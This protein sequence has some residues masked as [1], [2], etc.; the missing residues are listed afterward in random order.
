MNFG[1]LGQLISSITKGVE[2]GVSPLPVIIGVVLAVA[3]LAMLLVTVFTL[4]SIKRAELKSKKIIDLPPSAIQGEKEEEVVDNP[5][6]TTPWPIGEW[7]NK[8]L[9][10]KGYI[11]VNNI[12]RSFF[13]AMDFLKESLGSGYKYKLPWYMII[14]TEE[15]GKSSLLSGFTHDEIFDDEK[16]DPTCTWWFLR[17]GVV[18]DIKGNALIPKEGYNA[19]EKSWGIILSMLSRYRSAKPLNGIILTIPA[20]ELY[21]KNRVPLDSIKKRA[22]FIAKKLSFAQNYL[23]MKLPIYLVITKTDIVPGFQSFCSE[24]PVKNRSNML[25]WSSPYSSD[26][27]YYSR[28]LE[29]GFAAFENELNEIRMEIFSESSIIATRDGVFV[30]P[31]E[32]LSIKE[33]LACYI[34]TIFKSASV[35]ERFYFRGFY[36]TGDSKMVPLL[37]FDNKSEQEEAMA[38]L[39]TPDADINEVGNLTASF[40]N[41][42]FAPKKIFFFEDLL[43]KKVF[44]EDGI[45]SPM[46]SKVYQS[47]KSIFI[48]KVSTAAFVLIGSYGL[49]STKDQFNRNKEMLCPSLFKISSIIKNANDLTLKNLEDNGNEILSECT[50]QLLSMMQQ[51]NNARFSSL[52]V[53]ASWFS[54]INKNLTETLRI[55]YQRVVIRTIYMNLILKARTLF[56]MKPVH[57]SNDIAEVLNPN[58]SKEYKQLKSYVAELIELQ[59]NI[60]KFDSLRT[61]GDPKDLSDLIDYTFQGSLP[62]EFLDNYQQFRAILMNTPF[63]PLD[64]SPYKKV[65]YDVLISLFQGYL[66]TIFTTRSKNSIMAILKGFLDSLTRQNLKET[67]N[68]AK[69]KAFSKGLTAVCKELGQEG[70]TWLDKD[71]FEPDQEYDSFLDAVEILF[72]KETAQKLLDIT[73]INFGYLKARLSEFNNILNADVRR[74]AVAKKSSKEPQFPSSGIFLME[75]CLSELYSYAFME[76]PE[77]YQLI[78]DIPFGKMIFWDDELVQ[79]AYEIGKSF[80]QFI[81][82]S[83]KD[84]PKSMQEGITLLAKSN[85]CAVISSTIAKS[86][87]LVDSPVGLT[88]ELTSEE[89]LQKQVAELKGVAPRFVSLLQTLRE[90]KFSFVFGNLRAILNKIAFSLLDYIDKLLENQR[91]YYPN[92]LKFNYWNGEA[93]AGLHAYSASDMEELILYLQLQRKLMTRLASDFAEPIVEFLNSEI[94]FDKNFGNQGQ[95]TRWTRIADN[96]KALNK[97]DPTN[98]IS[99]VEK[100]ILRTLN[101]YDLDNITTK[102]SQKDLEGESGDYFTNIIKE[103]KRG[104]MARAEI[105]IRKRNIARYNALKDYYTKHLEKAFPFNNY[106]KSSRT[107]QDADLDAVREFFKMYDEFGG[108]PEAILDQIYQLKGE[109]LACY[110]FLQ[111]IH[112]LRI[113]FSD[114]FEQDQNSL[115]IGLEIN[116]NINKREESNTEYVIDRIFKPN[117]DANIEPIMKDK[118]AVWYFG[119]PIEIDFRWVNDDDQAPRPVYNPNDPDLIIDGSYAKVQ[120][121]GN[122]SVLRFL[123]KYKAETANVDLSSA[124]QTVL[125]FKIPLNNN[126]LTRIYVGITPFILKKPGESSVTYVKVP[127]TTGKMPQIPKSVILISDEAVLTNNTDREFFESSTENKNAEEIEPEQKESNENTVEPTRVEKVPNKK[128]HK[129]KKSP[130]TKQKPLQPIKTPTQRENVRQILETNEPPSLNENESMIEIIEEPEE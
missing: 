104:I 38:I 16:E 99:M 48:G 60:K 130:K 110:E 44:M 12:I 76:K 113:F 65:A 7:L 51:L 49:F 22:Q 18:L 29:E 64:L 108:T 58:N 32:L 33:S 81:S 5:N 96:I 3:F 73:A 84:F 106:D 124:N 42:E 92:N 97:K 46:K 24:I 1:F 98:S 63:P 109:A 95:L 57:E 100:F 77:D 27:V 61:S 6:A 50:N 21:G 10:K 40:R 127:K 62:K 72:G 20:D 2:G 82:T 111:K 59:K 54:N 8:Y 115:K 17:N 75:R 91:P 70:E 31:S 103:I 43:L 28:I 35:E 118:S 112:D 67:P 117:N 89:I 37:Q 45:A 120:C 30:F 80:E 53:P 34:D 23:G 36:F 47:N 79:Y 93:G 114:F 55:S 78:T 26:T 90:D 41:E 15:S 123:Q 14:G 9:I 83:I 122:W 74:Q 101:E 88:D 128:I 56:N 86:Q 129:Q 87:S 4:I 68:C 105:L 107:T 94:I 102:I 116:F 13:K 69:I 39:G 11:S 71:I 85:M 19:D 25:G 121:V 126:K 125:C 119:E 52:F 66:D